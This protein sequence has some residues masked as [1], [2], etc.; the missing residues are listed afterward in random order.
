MRSGHLVWGSNPWLSCCGLP[1]T[2]LVAPVVKGL[3]PISLARWPCSSP[4][5]NS[6]LWFCLWATLSRAQ[7]LLQGSVLACWGNL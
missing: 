1:G 7:G 2:L 3:F 5:Y 6:L 4:C